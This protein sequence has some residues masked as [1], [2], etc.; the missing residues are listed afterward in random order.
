MLNYGAQKIIIPKVAN[1]EE[2]PF[3]QID[4]G[5]VL[6][7]ISIV[8]LKDLSQSSYNKILKYLNSKLV[9]NY[10]KRISKNYSSGYKNISTNDLKK[11]RIP[12]KLFDEE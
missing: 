10:L 1:L 4:S 6:A 3:K 8:F 7:G 5:F 12:V 2:I 9:V 11:I